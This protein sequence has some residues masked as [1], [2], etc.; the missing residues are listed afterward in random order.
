MDEL[1]KIFE[2]IHSGKGLSPLK[3]SSTDKPGTSENH[4]NHSGTRLEYFSY[5]KNSSKEDGD[6]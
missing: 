2:N 1:D 5:Q 4:D 3:T 6:K